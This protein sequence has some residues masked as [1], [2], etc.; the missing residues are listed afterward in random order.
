MST[1]TANTHSWTRFWAWGDWRSVHY[2]LP[3]YAYP[4][5]LVLVEWFL[6]SFASLETKTFIGPTLAAVGASLLL[7]LTV[8]KPLTITRRD[9]VAEEMNA[10]SPELAEVFKKLSPDKQSKVSYTP[11]TETLFVQVCWLSVLILTLIWLWALFLSIKSPND[12]W[13]NGSVPANYVP[14]FINFFFGFLLS[15]IREGEVI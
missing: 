2:R 9:R 11:P 13:L 4:L 6:R 10:V 8:K 1:K 12:L 7:P 5:F 15:E 3:I 14:G